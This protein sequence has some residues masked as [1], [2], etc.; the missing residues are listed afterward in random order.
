MAE[1]DTK[2]SARIPNPE[3]L[4]V[5]AEVADLAYFQV[6]ENRDIVSVSPALE[7]ITGFKAEEV[8]GRSCLTMIRCKECLRG[9]KWGRRGLRESSL[10]HSQ[11]KQPRA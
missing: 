6:D 2:K 11:Q 10:T 5:L 3:E 4:G 9:L 7:E 1:E 8:L